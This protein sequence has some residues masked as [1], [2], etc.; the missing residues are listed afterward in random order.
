V[1]AAEGSEGGDSASASGSTS[2]SSTG[3]PPDSDSQDSE[4][5]DSLGGS[6]TV[7]DPSDGSTGNIDPT[8]TGGNATDGPGASCGDGQ[9]D[10]GE[11][12]DDGNEDDLDAC[13]N[14]CTAATCSD[15]VANGD[16]TDTD[17]G[18]SCDACEVGEGCRDTR[19]C[20]DV[21]CDLR[22]NVCAAPSCTDGI[23]NQGE[24][25][26]DCGAVCNTAPANVIDN[27]GFEMN[28]TGWNT[29]APEVNPQN[30]YFNDGSNNPVMEVDRDGNT[31]SSWLQEF[32]VS[33][34]DVDQVRT[35]SLDVGD[36]N[37]QADDVGGL[38]LR[39]VDP[40]GTPI[41]LAGISGAAFD[42]VAGNQ[43]AV[44]AQQ[45]GSFSLA[46]VQFTPTT[47][48]THTLELIEQTNGPGLGNGGGIIVDNVGISMITCP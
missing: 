12:C 16:E 25:G 21:V 43:I 45:T 34:D 44:D 41:P 24:L 5:S 3:T 35:L 29:V 32:E 46:I 2:V 7:T 28:T 40:G 48:G 1:G 4:G 36:R 19:D 9:Q 20:T 37:D 33:L 42:P 47:D 17:C 15:G 13:S 26:I 11:E 8:Q 30:A 10:P 14:R 38:F 18:G 6:T 27:G 31:T 23:L 39:I 22:R